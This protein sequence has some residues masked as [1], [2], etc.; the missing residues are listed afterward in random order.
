MRASVRPLVERSLTRAR[1]RPP[2]PP[3]RRHTAQP[4][5][6]RRVLHCPLCRQLA[7]GG[8]GDT[9]GVDVAAAA[10]APGGAPPPPQQQQHRSE[11]ARLYIF[12]LLPLRMGGGGPV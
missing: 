11:E 9:M 4:L 3:S 5:L 1:A 10:A 7:L 2:P 8:A 6:A 12:P